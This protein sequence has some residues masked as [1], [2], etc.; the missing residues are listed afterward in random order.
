M[1]QIRA[2]IRE[3][4]TSCTCPAQRDPSLRPSAAELLRHPFAAPP[5]DGRRIPALV[6]DPEWAAGVSNGGGGGSARDYW[7]MYPGGE[8][9]QPPQHRGASGPDAASSS[10][11][12]PPSPSF[13]AHQRHRQRPQ[14]RVI[15]EDGEREREPVRGA[16]EGA[17]GAVGDEVDGLAV[18]LEPGETAVIGKQLGMATTT[19]A[20]PPPLAQGAATA[21]AGV[22]PPTPAVEVTFEGGETVMVPRP[23]EEE[24]ASLSTQPPLFKVRGG[25]VWR[26]SPIR[27]VVGAVALISD[28]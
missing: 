11:D 6:H 27:F 28:D 9:E 4:L 20:V 26:L 10:A 25:R 14:H 15:S 8:R 7:G 1:T 5:A 18:A 23:A 24:A 13:S 3:I 16:A 19:A 12:T 21:M 22:L 2:F 17:V